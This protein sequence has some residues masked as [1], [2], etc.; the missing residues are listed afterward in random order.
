[1]SV[2]LLNKRKEIEVHAFLDQ[3]YFEAAKAAITV[4]N[5]KLYRAKTELVEFIKSCKL[6]TLLLESDYTNLSQAVE[7]RN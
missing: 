1:M 2:I 6:K 5:V 3:R 7:V 4:K